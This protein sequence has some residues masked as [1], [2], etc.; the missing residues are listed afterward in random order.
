MQILKLKHCRKEENVDTEWIEKIKQILKRSVLKFWFI[1]VVFKPFGAWTPFYF[2]VHFVGSHINKNEIS[3]VPVWIQTTFIKNIKWKSHPI[4]ALS[5]DIYW[6]RCACFAWHI[7]SIFGD[8]FDK[9]TCNSPCTSFD[10]YL[11]KTLESAVNA[12][13]HKN[14]VVK[15]S[16]ILIVSAKPNIGEWFWLKLFFHSCELEIRI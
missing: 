6:E 3:W 10:L 14:V 5:N 9:N 1:A 2:M 4:F 12:V 11:V 7:F 8:I 16:S 13:S 15:S